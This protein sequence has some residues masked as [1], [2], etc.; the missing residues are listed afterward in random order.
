MKMVKSLLLGSAA[1]L[2]AVAGAQ[3][4]DLPV[5]AKP[6]EYVKVCSLYGAGFYYIPGTDTCIKIGGFVR[7]EWLHNAN[8]SFAAYSAGGQATFTRTTDT[9]RNRSRWIMS[10]DVRSQT[11]YGTLRAY[12]R[13][14]WQWTSQDATVGGSQ[15][16]NGIGNALAIGAAGGTGT[17]SSVVYLDRAFIQFAGFTFGKTQS[18]FDFFCTGCYSL[19]T[20]LLYVDTGGSGTPVAAYTAQFGNGVSATLSIEDYT[21]QR[22][23]IANAAA[24]FPANA[25][26]PS[27][28]RGYTVPD[29]VGALRV[30]QAWG[31]AQISGAL[32]QNAASYYI[33]ANQ[34]AHPDEKWGWAMNAGL[35]LKMP[36]DPKDTFS[37]MGTYCEGASRYCS[38]PGGGQLGNG[39]MF[40]LVNTT[41][42]G[43]GWV[44]D[45][46]FN[47]AVVGSQ[48]EL[49]TMWSGTA[50]F[51][52]YWT[53]SLRQSVY[54]S[55]LNY[56]TNSVS[57]DTITCPAVAVAA[58]NPALSAGCGDWSAWTVGSRLLWNPVANLDIGLDVMYMN[59]DSALKGGQFATAAQGL[60]AVLN[61]GDTH[62]WSGVFR[63]QR[64]FW[65]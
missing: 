52:H 49:P 5:K 3:A 45:A 59:V 36:W 64:N 14:G 23:A 39:L 9:L 34:T 16:G 31:S 35:T 13:A 1:G 44:A 53:P 61:F 62:V 25:A 38:N 10:M 24:A 56:E 26:I 43:V 8:G 12:A 57:V 20:N 58:G 27:L 42:V 28:S 18:F 46:Y 19:Q 54:G 47:A 2:F 21:E 51:E 17:P 50:A 6:V 7:T 30:D 48:L 29:I 11:E 4:A 33:G 65:P 63:V 55:Y 37:I 32:H 22:L 15:G 40:G 60:P 41:T